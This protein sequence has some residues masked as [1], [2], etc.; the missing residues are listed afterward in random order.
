[1]RTTLLLL[2]M[3]V[4]APAAAEPESCPDGKARLVV[5]LRQSSGKPAEHRPVSIAARI[6]DIDAGVR[7]KETDD[8][9]RVETCLDKTLTYDVRA[10]E[11]VEKNGITLPATVALKL[12]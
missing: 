2:S 11:G 9:G 5:I 6:D 3:L 4:A 12:K 10:A 1:M 7:V 8:Q